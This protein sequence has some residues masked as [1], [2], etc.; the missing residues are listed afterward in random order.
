MDHD[1]R[2]LVSWM[3]GGR[4]ADYAVEFI[5]DL[6]SRLDGRVHLTTDGYLS[7]IDAVAGAFD[8]RGVDYAQLVKHYGPRGEYTHAHREAVL[9][10]P[11]LR[12]AT[13]SHI[14]RLNLTLRMSVRRYNR[15]TNAFSKKFANHVHRVALYALWYNFIRPH[16]SLGRGVTPAMAAGLA[17]HPLSWWWL[18]EDVDRRAP[19][20]KRLG[21][22]RW[23]EARQAA[24]ALDDLDHGGH[25]AQD[26]R[27][28]GDE[29]HVAGCRRDGIGDR[30]DPGVGGTMVNERRPHPD[31]QAREQAHE[32]DGQRHRRPPNSGLTPREASAMM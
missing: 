25:V 19:K 10:D 30:D 24:D 28:Q 3:V 27:Q 31:R 11:D 14:E 29:S 26:K 9:G 8:R 5:E 13:T 23:L 16:S 1:T 15:R 22:R 20:P 2:L 4:D 12:D 32:S 17:E 18:L 7:Y 21:I 6:A